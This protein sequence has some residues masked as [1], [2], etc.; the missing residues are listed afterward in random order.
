MSRQFITYFGYGSLVNRHTRPADEQAFPARLYGWRRVWGHRVQAPA[1]TGSVSRTT[2]C[3]LTVEKLTTQSAS[4]DEPNIASPDTAAKQKAEQAYVDGVVVRIPIEDLPLLDEREAG[5]NRVK[6]PASDF[7]LPPTCNEAY[8]HVYVSKPSNAGRSNQQYP[9]LQSYI[10]CVLA[11]YCAV[12][13]HNGMQQFVDST[14]GWGGVIENERSN[15]KYP[16]AVQL[17]DSQ[18]Q[19]FDR[20]VSE[21]RSRGEN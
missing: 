2:C 9:I 5:Y 20:L 6:V 19:L 1:V 11:G 12:F 13:E 21:R 17:A 18:L 7:D 10:D 3:S 15:P 16:R 8:V 14:V 4:T